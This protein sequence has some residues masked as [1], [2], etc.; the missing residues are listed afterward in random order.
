MRVPG[1]DPWGVEERIPDPAAGEARAL[2]RGHEL[3]ALA[4]FP[5]TRLADPVLLGT[6]PFR[7]EDAL[8]VRWRTTGDRT[9]LTFY[10][11]S[12]TLPLG[13]R[14]EWTRP[15]VEGVFHQWS[16]VESGPFEGLRVFRAATVLQGDDVYRYRYD[17]VAPGEVPDSLPEG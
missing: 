15:V 4:L 3:H 2:V 17:R 13:M 7:G 5:E 6:A 10:S 12:D 1:R 11:P 14:A 9:L 8:A 16:R